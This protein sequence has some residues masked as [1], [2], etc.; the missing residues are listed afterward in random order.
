LKNYLI[1]TGGWAY[2]HVPGANSLVA[3]SRAFNFVEVNSTFYQIPPLK[4]VERWRKLV[5][6]EFQFSVRAN[7]AITHKHK[8]QPTEEALEA[9]EKMKKICD[10]LDADVLHV[11][12]PPS[13]KMTP[14]A[15]S[16]LAD[17]LGSVELGG[18]RLALEVR[19]PD[20][21]GL[22][23]ELA[24]IMQDHNMVHCVDLSIGEAPAYESDVL[25]TRL[26][27]KGEHN[28]YQPSDEELAEIDRKASSSGSQR[29]A[30]SFHFVRMYKDAARLISYKRTGGFPSITDFTGLSSLEEV[31]REDTNFPTSKQELVHHQGWKLFDA[32]HD[33]RVHANELLQKLPERTY[34]DLGDVMNELRQI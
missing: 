1:G 3:Y 9:F 10:A 29:I 26:F 12:T 22:P 16:G 23:N 4:E 18:L 20:L 14:A 32:T 8:L 33:K 31:L 34:A 2:F 19:S 24:R 28:V 30:M 13:L 25:Y 21:S 5:P 17:F 7:R 6:K 15:I 11:Q 27:G